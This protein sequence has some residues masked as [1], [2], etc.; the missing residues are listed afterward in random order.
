M[1]T[2]HQRGGN[3]QRRLTKM[4]SETKS[5]CENVT[6]STAYDRRVD[7]TEF[8]RSIRY[9]TDR[10]LAWGF[11]WTDANAAQPNDIDESLTRAGFSDVVESVMSSIQDILN[12]ADRLLKGYPADSTSKVTATTTPVPAAAHGVEDTERSKSLVVELTACI[13][14]LYDL[15]RSRR[16]ITTAS[17]GGQQRPLKG[18]LS[19][20][21]RQNSLMDF[22]KNPYYQEDSRK[23]GD[24][25]M[26][27]SF[28]PQQSSEK[29]PMREYSSSAEAP[30]SQKPYLIDRSALQL[31]GPA[32]D[33]SP[34]PYEV[35]AASSNSRVIGRIRT[36]ATPL[37][38]TSR[39]ATASI[40]VE[41]T[42]MTVLETQN[43]IITIPASQRL[44]KVDR[45]LD[46]LVQNA[47][48]SH[49]GLLRFLGYYVDMP[50]SRYAFIYEMPVNYFPFLRDPTDLLNESKPQPLVSFFQTGDN[51]EIPNLEVRFR[52]AY[53]LLMAVL[54]LRSQNTV[55]GNINSSNI[56]IFPSLDSSGDGEVRLAQDF[57]RPYLT[58]F[59]QFSGDA[60]SPEPLVSSMYR[61]PDDKKQL[62]DEAAW[63]YDL[64]SLG[65][66]LLEIGLWLPI[67]RCW[68]M[69]Y[70]NSMF[71]R[72]IE[73]F[74]VPRLGP[75]CGSAY[76]HMV[77]LCLDA[78]NFHLSTQPIQDL[79]FRVPQIYHYPV[80]DLSDPDGMFSFSMNFLYTI[81]K[82]AWSCAQIDIF[83][84]PP[85]KDLDDSL[86]LALVPQTD[87]TI[88]LQRSVQDA[89]RGEAATPRPPIPPRP[90]IQEQI[91]LPDVASPVLEMRE[92]SKG[93]GYLEEKRLKKRTI[94]RFTDV[95]IPQRHLDEWNFDLMPRL[96]K[97][98]QKVLKESAESCSATLLMTGESAETAKTTICVS[99]S[100]VKRVRSALKRYWDVNKDSWDLVVL[101]GDV[102]RST[103]GK[104]CRRPPWSESEGDGSQSNSAMVSDEIE[105]SKP[106]PNPFYQPVP[107]C[108]ASL[109]AFR[110]DEHSP[111]VTYGGA[112]LVDGKPFGMTVHHV[113]EASSEESEEI[114]SSSS[115]PLR[116]AGGS[117]LKN[118]P[119]KFMSPWYE[120]KE[121]SDDDSLEFEVSEE[122]DD[123]DY[124]VAQSSDDDYYLSDDYSSD[125]DV[126]CDQEGNIASVGDTAG[127]DPEDEP[128]VGVTQP[129]LD[130][131]HENFWP[132]LEDRDQEHMDS[133]NF[134]Y[135]YASSGVRRW[136]QKGIKH[137]ID[138]ALIKV[139]DKRMQTNNAVFD[140]RNNTTSRGQHESRAVY[141]DKV[142]RMEDLG[143]LTVH[144]CGRT[145]GFQSGQISRAMA[146][147]KL[148]GRHTFSNSFCVN[149]GFGGELQ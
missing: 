75:K 60:P 26:S 55:H 4:Y 10:L 65:L 115:P 78:P 40:L 106:D 142:A 93:N 80:L 91:G 112:I 102:G 33:A 17:A 108:G 8:G 94:R 51:Q 36:S 6:S 131:I 147:V 29:K 104:R 74:Y 124:S 139:N 45:T 47:S 87:M 96:S 73:S 25:G 68:K 98:L 37:L 72:R 56:L 69:K 135:V 16:D 120:A 63:A 12:Q 3:L 61:H 82:I 123:D 99:C 133:H 134:G 76:L 122:E 130:D 86:P 30:L 52:L 77:Q 118:L 23:Q 2:F 79:S 127:V 66:V 114:P 143:G 50:N 132:T 64:Y 31:S 5:S 126:I 137:E 14:V 84:A 22:G 140:R 46:Q 54:H 100:N 43:T 71:K 144:C 32:H 57:R 129:A 138:W 15:S 35:V 34:P 141:L 20:K 39:E 113:L 88:A 110:D 53:D 146:L 136:I 121:A 9:Q 19:E 7:D 70:T 83:S 105:L 21:A 13:D 148:H 11:D 44:E 58:S 128:P 18:K 89:T 103:L 149:G 125:D 109:G 28:A 119:T 101:R 67:S 62:D 1:A 145:S 95:D 107:T 97:L 24:F 42:P 85:A 90:T 92:R 59:A 38:S 116:S 27:A 48:V 117:W 49:L 41:F 111:P 81:C